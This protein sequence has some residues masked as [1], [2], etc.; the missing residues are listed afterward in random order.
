M[1]KWVLGILCIFSMAMLWTPMEAVAEDEWQAVQSISVAGLTLD[2]VTP[3]YHNGVNGEQG[4]ADAN[5]E[6]ANASFDASTGTL[7]LND[8]NI[9]SNQKGIVWEY[10]SSGAHDLTIVL[11]ENSVN[12]IVCTATSDSIAINGRSGFS[13]G[14]PSVRI[15]GEGTL[16]LHGENHAIWVWEDIQIEGGAEVY[17]TGNGDVAVCNNNRYGTVTIA[18]NALLST[19]GDE[20]GIGY[21]NYNENSPSILEGT[22][23]AAGQVSAFK[24]APTLDEST[25]WDIFVGANESAATRWD[26]LTALN[27]QDY[28]YAKVESVGVK[29]AI[30]GTV[31]ITGTPK[32]DYT[33]TA[34][35]DGLNLAD[36][37]MVTIAYQWKRE[38]EAIGTKTANNTYTLTEED[39]GRAITVEVSTYM[40]SGNLVSE[41]VNVEIPHVCEGTIVDVVGATCTEAGK[42]AYYHCEGCGKNYTDAQATDEIADLDAW[43]N[44]PA[45]GHVY[46]WYISKDATPTQKGEMIGECTVCGANATEET[47]VIEAGGSGEVVVVYP[48]TNAIETQIDNADAVKKLVL[49]TDDERD[50]VIGGT[51]LSIILETTDVT[52]TV[53]VE[54]KEKLDEKLGEFEAGM[55]IDISLW[56]Q[57]GIEVKRY[58]EEIADAVKITIAIPESMQ[59][60]SDVTRTYKVLKLHKGIVTTV[61]AIYDAENEQLSFETD[62]FSLYMLAFKDTELED[63]ELESEE[64]EESEEES[65]ETEEESEEESEETEEKSE[66]S[67]ESEE[68]EEDS[69][70]ETE[71]EEAPKTGDTSMMYFWWMLMLFSAVAV[72]AGVKGKSTLK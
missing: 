20:Y 65:E 38:G 50:A 14:G 3:Y 49:L 36:D 45:L 67:E 61:D 59:A 29:T 5:A 40:Y 51:K 35:V 72:F 60:D 22:V 33:L 9:N 70:L 57:V 54:E 47:P 21:S 12:S 71:E 2:S 4:T 11:T 8:L 42:E 68:T 15:T 41:A 52:Q 26:G 31:V 28:K 66:E 25:K 16:N 13:S 56:K 19:T 1:K 7:T 44:I 37:E 39:M 43:G 62:E 58:V 6:N 24:T 64:T 53:E 46:T 18:G 48:E 63:S 30:S 10:K 32:C 69:E 23:N 34:N 17:A 27:G 55:Y